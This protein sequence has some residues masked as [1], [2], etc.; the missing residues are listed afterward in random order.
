MGILDP[1]H[2]IKNNLYQKFRVSHLAVMGGYLFDPGLFYIV[3]VSHNICRPEEFASNIL[4]LKLLTH[5]TI[6]R[7]VQLGDSDGGDFSVLFV[8][9]VL[10]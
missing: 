9:L 3:G 2:N 7:L 1:N 10:Q 6:D 8:H 5:I 4:V